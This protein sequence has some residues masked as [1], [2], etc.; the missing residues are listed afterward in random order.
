M[1]TD[2]QQ[3]YTDGQ[4]M[5]ST[6]RWLR[7]ANCCKKRGEANDYGVHPSSEWKREKGYWVRVNIAGDEWVAQGQG[8]GA[9]VCGNDWFWQ[10]CQDSGVWSQRDWDWEKVKIIGKIQQVTE[11]HWINQQL[12]QVKQLRTRKGNERW[13]SL[14]RTCFVWCFLYDVS[15]MHWRCR[16]MFI[17]WTNRPFW[18]YCID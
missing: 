14:T 18:F 17:Q 5:K 8:S 10:Q 3:A 16:F 12:W 2:P 13:Q 1:L 15:T 6:G 11:G 7:Y 9:R 4:W